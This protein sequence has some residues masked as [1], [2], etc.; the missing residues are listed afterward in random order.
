MSQYMNLELQTL[1]DLLV[2]RITEYDTML[3]TKVFSEEEFTQCKQILAELHAAIKQKSEE[4]GYSME[5]VLP[6]F[7][8]KN[9]R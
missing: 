6:S 1:I 8:N 7:P 4:E 3:S 9:R 2:T 5:K